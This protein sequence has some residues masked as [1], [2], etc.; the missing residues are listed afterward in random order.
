MTL[1]IVL[2]VISLW[3]ALAVLLAVLLG[4]TISVAD[5]KRREELRT[6]HPQEGGDRRH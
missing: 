3:V 6:A 5:R 1:P 2:A 4:R